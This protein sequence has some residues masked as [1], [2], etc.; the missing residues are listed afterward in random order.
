MRACLCACGVPVRQCCVRGSSPHAMSTIGVAVTAVTCVN[1]LIRYLRLW[2]AKQEV[3]MGVACGV[4]GALLCALLLHGLQPLYPLLDFD[5]NGA[6]HD[7]TSR[8]AKAFVD[9]P[10]MVRSRAACSSAA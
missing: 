4:G 10:D 1:H 3:K 7:A 8:L 6:H 2:S 5:L 9:V